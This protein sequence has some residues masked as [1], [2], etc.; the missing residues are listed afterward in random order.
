M[1]LIE[2]MRCQT[3]CSNWKHNTRNDKTRQR[4]AKRKKSEER[5]YEEQKCRPIIE[6]ADSDPIAFPVVDI[7]MRYAVAICTNIEYVQYC[8]FMGASFNQRDGEE[9]IS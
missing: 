9:Q 5:K 4:D 3:F 2:V 1:A 8:R 6:K 7:R